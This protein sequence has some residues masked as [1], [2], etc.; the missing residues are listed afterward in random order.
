MNTSLEYVKTRLRVSNAA[1]AFAEEC[2]S[3]DAVVA[4][5][6]T[7]RGYRRAWVNMCVAMDQRGDF[8]AT[9]DEL[10]IERRFFAACED[11]ACMAAVLKVPVVVTECL[12]LHQYAGKAAAGLLK[13]LKDESPVLYEAF[14][15][16]LAE[17]VR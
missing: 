16:A 11:V 9:P 13:W 10:A 8:D 5:L 6:G 4:V 17:E 1:V 14:G 7:Y 15:A 12:S 3:V 2:H